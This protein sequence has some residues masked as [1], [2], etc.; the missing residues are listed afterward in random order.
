MLATFVIGLREGLEAALIVGIIAAFLTRSGRRDALVRMWVGVGA[1]VLLCLA[2]GIGLQVV[3]AGLPQRQQEMLECVVAAVAVLMISYMVLW[4]RRHSRDLRGDLQA[5]AGSALAS[6]S[7]LA[8]ASM[9]FLA[10][11]REGFETAVFLLAAFQSALS[12]VEAVVGIVLGLA[13][14]IVL[15]YLIYRGGVRLNL[16]RFFRITGVV[17]VLVAGGLVM[18]TLRAAYEAGWLTGGQQQAVDLSA[19]ARPGS[20]VESLLT[21]MLGIRS[22]MPL[23]EVLAWVL[24][25]VPML[26][27]V[28]WP[29]KRMPSPAGL[30][31][32]LAGVGA[33][34]LVLALA[35]AVLAPSAPAPLVQA[36][37]P[38][39]PAALAGTRATAG[40]ADASVD[41]TASVQLSGLT[42]G[43][44]GRLA[45]TPGSTVQAEITATVD[46]G[47]ST[48][49]VPLTVG[50]ADTVGGLA[51]VDLIGSAAGT[52]LD[53]DAVV[54]A[55]LPA[56]V[57]GTQVA[58]ANG[59]RF[60]VGLR[61]GDA[62]TAM[63]VAYVDTT[64]A[65][66]RIDPV[67][68]EILGVD[69][70]RTTALRVTTPA[71]STIPVGDVA[72]LTAGWTEQV[73]ADQV[74]L[75]RAAAGQRDQHQVLGQVVPA[76]VG[77]FGVT[78][79]IAAALVGRR[80]SRVVTGSGPAPDRRPPVAA[81]PQIPAPS[82]TRS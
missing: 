24:Y 33:G 17:L 20:V 26:A 75:A 47:A 55:G 46:G 67:S 78:L 59:G 22:A 68:G 73:R 15:G 38:A 64:Q 8:L 56:T 61:S 58:A 69:L 42:A 82:V 9:A 21:G 62:D 30:R 70:A 34:A 37:A 18:S 77:V 79:L 10:V 74:A 19:V 13:L 51:A 48:I 32:L 29:V 53:A 66:V 41:G 39:G 14:A 23:V 35:F 1:A 63:A 76:L 40:Q 81:S 72:S 27:V 36:G 11:I 3:N 12:P 7:A 60:P 44:T 52:A 45:L 54:A 65:T 6:G 71:G 25:V 80:R 16:S 31:R 4:M 49:T 2:V 5:A 43:D 57:T 28:L 50:G